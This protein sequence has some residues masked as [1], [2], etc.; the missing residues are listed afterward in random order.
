VFHYTRGVRAAYRVAKRRSGRWFDP[1]LFRAMLAFRDDGAFWAGLAEPDVTAVEP[2]D[3]VMLADDDR[4][5]VIAEGFAG[6]VDAKSRWTGEHCE[7]VCTIANGVAVRLG[8]D[9]EAR[10]DLARAA[11]LHDI[12]KLAISN[13]I[14]DKPGPLTAGEWAAVRRHPRLT[15][16][17]LGRVPSLGQLAPIA[18]VYAALTAERPYRAA[19]QPERALDVMRADVPRRLDGDAFTALEALIVTS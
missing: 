8:L 2:G 10:R 7:R 13:R 19:L 15:E 11:L 17:I 1:E 16:Q 14:L 18:D 3:R 5:D 6:V 9:D 4:L 12:G